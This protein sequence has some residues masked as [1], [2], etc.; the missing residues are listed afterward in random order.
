ML[1]TEDEWKAYC[2]ERGTPYSKRAEAPVPLTDEER[3]VVYELFDRMGSPIIEETPEAVADI[4]NEEISVF[5][6]GM[7][8]AEDCA[9]KIQS[10]VEIWLAEHE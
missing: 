3:M 9:K 2:K 4:V 8:N 7:G 6:S 1:M 10:R 5:L